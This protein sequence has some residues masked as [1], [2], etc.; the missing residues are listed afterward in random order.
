MS[1]ASILFGVTMGP[2][3][4][5]LCTRGLKTLHLRM[6]KHASNAMTVARFLFIQMLEIG[7]I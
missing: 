5:W 7:L 4:A 2:H 6:E 3:E 1:R